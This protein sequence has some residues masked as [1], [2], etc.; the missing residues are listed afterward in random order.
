MATPWLGTEDRMTEARRLIDE[1]IAHVATNADS[2]DKGGWPREA[3]A[4]REWCRRAHRFL[5]ETK[6]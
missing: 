2:L 3:E 4:A 6:P 5:R 1:A